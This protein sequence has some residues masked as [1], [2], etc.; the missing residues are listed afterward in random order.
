MAN[1]F[2]QNIRYVLEVNQADG[3][4][5][6]ATREVFVK[7]SVANSQNDPV[8]KEELAAIAGQEKTDLDAFV[9]AAHTRIKAEFSIT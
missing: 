4:M 8:V 9:L 1:T 6:S 5:V 3:L 7:D 2:Q